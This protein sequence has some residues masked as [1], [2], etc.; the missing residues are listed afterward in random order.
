MLPVSDNEETV[1]VTSGQS[2]EPASPPPGSMSTPPSTGRRQSSTSENSL[3]DPANKSARPSSAPEERNSSPILGP[4]QKETHPSRTDLP[5][6]E[7]STE[8]RIERL[9]RQRPEVFKS[10]WEEIGFVFSVSM[11]QVLTVR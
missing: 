10:I 2:E 11:S 5:A 6:T 1:V 9:G 8:A 7:E 3:W 4:Q